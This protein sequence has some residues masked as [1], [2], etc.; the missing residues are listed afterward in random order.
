[1]LYAADI[2]AFEPELHSEI[3]Q[4]LFLDEL[5]P[6]LKQL[7]YPMIQP[8]LVEEAKRRNLV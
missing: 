7:T 2:I 6:D 5:P 4:V 3:E 8:K 1:M